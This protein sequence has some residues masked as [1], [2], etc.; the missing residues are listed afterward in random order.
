MPNDSDEGWARDLLTRLLDGLSHDV[1]TLGD[2]QREDFARLN[3][4][5]TD[6]ER[7]ARSAFLRVEEVERKV[8]KLE[9]SDDAS[10]ISLAEIRA[11]SKTAGVVMGFIAGIVGTILATFFMKLLGIIP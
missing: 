11:V 10:T 2:R 7:T 9:T 4:Q 5:Q 3:A 6:T 1:A 8:S